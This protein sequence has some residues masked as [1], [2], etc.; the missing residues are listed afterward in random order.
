VISSAGLAEA[1]GWTLD[2]LGDAVAALDGQLAD[3]GVRIDH[4]PAP[5]SPP[6]VRGLRARDR[7]LTDA[8]RTAL[9]QL[10][11]PEPTL[12]VETARV[13]DAIAHAPRTL[14]ER[15]HEFDPAAIVA[16][17]QRGLIRRHP[18]GG[19]LELTD[20]TLCGL[21]ITAA[22]KPSAQDRNT[23]HPR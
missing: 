14:T 17:Q 21:A 15:T 22:A 19:Y 5:T 1:L 9:H 10:H 18:G 12:D 4:D 20:D 8:Q 6:P 3:T 11:E 13:L 2:R 23:P 16:L 7:N